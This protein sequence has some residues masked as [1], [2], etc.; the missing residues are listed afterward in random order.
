MRMKLALEHGRPVAD[1]DDGELGRALLT[2]QSL[3]N[4]NPTPA[5]WR[6]RRP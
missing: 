6:Q 1:M 4:L 3:L 5:L 2:M